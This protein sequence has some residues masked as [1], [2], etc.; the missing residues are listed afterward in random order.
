[1][2]A[3][4]C[5]VIQ[6]TMVEVVLPSLMFHFQGGPRCGPV[7]TRKGKSFEDLKGNCF[8]GQS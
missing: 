3:L 7:A 2:K 1:M 5:A 8:Q 6:G 4:L